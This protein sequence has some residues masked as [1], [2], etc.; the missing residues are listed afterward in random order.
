[1]SKVVV[2]IEK[3]LC[4]ATEI[5]VPDELGLDT[6][7]EMEYAEEKVRK[8]YKNKEIVLT[9]DDD[10]GMSCIMV[11]HEDGTETSWTDM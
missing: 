1:M 3:T 10:T 6:D 2:Y 4:K 8:M 11:K 9:E 7:E 5:D